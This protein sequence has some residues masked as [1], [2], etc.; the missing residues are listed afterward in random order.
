VSEIYPTSDRLEVERIPL[1][2]RKPK[3]KLKKN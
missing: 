1:V 2:T 3:L